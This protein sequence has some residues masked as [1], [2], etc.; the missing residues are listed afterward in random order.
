MIQTGF[1][2]RAMLHADAQIKFGNTGSCCFQN[3]IETT[4]I[5]K[6][7]AVKCPILSKKEFGNSLKVVTGWFYELPKN[8]K[9]D[10]TWRK[11]S[12]F[13]WQLGRCEP[14][15]PPTKELCV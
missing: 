11:I 15:F 3:Q 10:S 5:K 7:E 6:L 14:S 13:V 9:R 8:K 12:K 2:V 4:K 1:S